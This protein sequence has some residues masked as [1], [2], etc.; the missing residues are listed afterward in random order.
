MSEV[1]DQGR[2]WHFYV[3]D[4]IDF[5][6]KVLAYSEGLDLEAF[7]ADSLSYDATLRNLQLIGEAATRIPDEIRQLHPEIPWR[8]IV[9]T[10]NSLTRSY[11]SIS[12]TKI[13]GTVQDAVPDLIPALRDL[14][15]SAGE[16]PK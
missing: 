1:V 9:G 15:A 12:D 5:S 3:Q 16:D 7:I 4:M 11:L 10:C 2:P 6:Q 14:L 8:A 13:W